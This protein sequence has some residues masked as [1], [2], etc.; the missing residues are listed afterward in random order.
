M[1]F[2]VTGKAQTGKTRWLQSLLAK[3][4]DAGVSVFGVLAPGVWV[5]ASLLDGKVRDGAEKRFEKR[6]IENVLLPGGEVLPFAKRA[7][8]AKADGTFND[9]SQSARANLSWEIS[10]AAL[11]RVNAH[12]RALGSLGED[13]FAPSRPGVLLIDELGPLELLRGGGLTEAVSL[14]DVGPTSKYSHAIVV[15]RESLASLAQERF[16]AAWGACEMIVPDEAQ[17]ARII[18]CITEAR[19]LI[20]N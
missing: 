19:L 1:L 8:L 11:A 6:G 14:L 2:V 4:Q 15:V 16:A 9:G 17:A 13:G 12:L 5:E 18:A 7:D 10:D 20:C 3:L